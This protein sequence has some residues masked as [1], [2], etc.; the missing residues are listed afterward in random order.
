MKVIAYLES[1]MDP[2]VGVAEPYD[3]APRG[4]PL[5]REKSWRTRLV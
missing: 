1:L 2:A 3:R 4:G 5:T